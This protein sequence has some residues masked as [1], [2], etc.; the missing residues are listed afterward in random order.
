MK[1]APLVKQSDTFVGIVAVRDGEP[2]VWD[3]CGSVYPLRETPAGVVLYALERKPLALLTRKERR[4]RELHFKHR[5][6]S[7]QVDGKKIRLARGLFDGMAPE[8][9]LPELVRWADW[10]RSYGANV[11]GF[12]GSARSLLRATLER[13]VF[14]REPEIPFEWFPLGG[15]IERNVERGRYDFVSSWD[16]TAAYPSTYPEIHFPRNYIETARGSLN[17]EGFAVADVKVPP[18]LF[19]PLPVRVPE[20][21]TQVFP[22]AEEIS[23]FWPLNELRMAAESGCKVNLRRVWVARGRVPIFGE[24]WNR[25]VVEGRSLPGIAGRIAKLTTAALWGSFTA[26]GQA[27]WWTWEDNADGER[28]SY[29]GDKPPQS[30]AFAARIVSRIRERLYREALTESIFIV[31]MHTDGI[32]CETG[33]TLRPSGDALGEWRVKR[34]GVT[35]DYHGPTKYRLFTGGEDT[36]DGWY[37]VVAGRNTQER[38]EAAFRQSLREDVNLR[39]AER[40]SAI[41]DARKRAALHWSDRIESP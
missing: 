5:L 40:R 37:Y 14:W 33:V 19:G 13:P 4:G 12:P 29:G 10:L 22:F 3:E 11:A 1:I 18:L 7:F 41:I 24:Q 36:V 28:I 31:G 32:L 25:A 27:E 26:H 17:D 34:T 15:R 8:D 9:A 23:G 30:P 6:I 35:L 16:I 39:K 2:F 21:H 20:R 38:A